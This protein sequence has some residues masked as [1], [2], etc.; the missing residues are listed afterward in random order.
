MSG[1]E[2][3]VLGTASQAPTRYRNHNGYLLRWDGYGVLFDPGEGTQ[4][5]MVLAGVA[6]SSIDRICL[7]HL[8]GDHCL[9]LPGVLGRMSLDQLDRVVDV[10]FPAESSA[11]FDHLVNASIGR[12]TVTLRPRPSSEGVLSDDPPLRLSARRL[13]HSVPTLGWRLEEPDG[14]TMLPSRLAAAGVSGPDVGRLQRDGVLTTG[15]GG[16][17]HLDDVSVARP[18]QTFGFVMD[19]RLC[20]AAVSLAA[21]VDLLVCESTFL[22]DDQDLATAYGHMTA[23][24]AAWLARESGARRLVLTHFSQRYTD[25]ARF[26]AEAGEIF[27][28]VVVARDLDVVAVPA[29]PPPPG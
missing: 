20:D 7:T 9:G 17:V 25:D 3:V 18:G 8:H 6:S 4:R 27:P 22:S 29:R 12:R 19:T 2:L 21:G 10:F 11:T 5:Q 16:T 14:R 15:A 26:L 1:R 23:S 28:D 24:Q 13:D